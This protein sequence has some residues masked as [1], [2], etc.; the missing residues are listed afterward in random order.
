MGTLGF[1]YRP[2]YFNE[3]LGR[4]KTKGNDEITLPNLRRYGDRSL[5]IGITIGPY[6]LTLTIEVTN[7]ISSSNQIER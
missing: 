6:M 3:P 2:D 5:G 4:Q 7:E 1:L